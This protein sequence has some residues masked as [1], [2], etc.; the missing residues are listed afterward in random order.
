MRHIAI[1][2]AAVLALTGAV[3]AQEAPR[4]RIDSGVLAGEATERADIFRDIPYA[5]PPLGPLRWAPPKPAAPWTGER[6]A[7]DKGPSCPQPM[8]ADG[9]PNFA[10][11]NGPMSE[12]CLQL[13]VYAPKAAARG[14]KPAAVL[15]WLHGGGNRQG[16]GW[17][18]D[19]QNFAR[20]G[21][22]LVTL[23]YRLG[24]L[25]WFAHPA[26][27]RAA[28]PGEALANYGLMDQIAA[29]KWVQ[30]NVAAFGGDPANVTIA[31]ESAGGGDVLDLLATPSARP[32]FAKAIVESGGGWTAPSSLAKAEAA[33]AGLADQLGLPGARA[34]A[35]QLRAVPVAALLDKAWA[36]GFGA[37]PDGRLMTRT[38]AQALAFGQAADVPLIIGAN[39]GEDS[40]LSEARLKPADIAAAAP[41]AL[42]AA[43][44]EAAAEGE[45]RLGREIYADRIMVAPARWVA[46]RAAGGQPAWLYHFSYVGARFRPLGMTRAFHVAEIQYVF[47]YWGRRTPMSVVSDEDRAMATLMHSCWVAFAR[48]GVPA[49][50]TGE[51]W[52]AYDPASDRLMEFGSAG[53]VRS[54][55]RKRQLDAQEAAALPDLALTN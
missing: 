12:D 26:L 54:G 38:A 33:G 52:P 7:V 37:I 31:G 17:I 29:L 43:Y 14:A 27:T 55:F 10:G 5:A 4:V 34:T 28:R 8:N 49:C 41:P 32:L 6:P 2:L 30:R 25:G 13:N 53:G 51:P 39:S 24:P 48:T 15:V 45:A 47:E 18:Y 44:P 21:V 11:A 16:A 40:L 1:A 22:V 50:A 36:G 23:N 9:S 35:A 19:G 3:R 42:K 20:D 46:A